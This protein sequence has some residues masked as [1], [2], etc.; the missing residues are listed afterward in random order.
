MTVGTAGLLLDRQLP[1]FDA[2]LFAAVVVDAPPAVAYAA[3]RD[4]EPDDVAADFPLMRVMG[5]VRELPSRL[6]RRTANATPA[7]DAFVVLEEQPGTE[8]VVGMIGKFA[9][10]RQLEFREVEPAGFAGFAEPGYGKTAVN[11]R[12]QPY[13]EGRSLLTTETRTHMT[14]PTSA[15]QFRRY[16]RIIRPFAGLI[17][18][19]WLRLAATNATAS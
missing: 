3:V 13:G 17:M 4:L 11:F 14:D 19:R 8:F 12:V 6:G 15:A 7:N 18:R 5:R 1:D 16:W 10:A 9:T 2:R